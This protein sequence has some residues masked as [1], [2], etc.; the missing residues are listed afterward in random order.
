MFFR[1]PKFLRQLFFF[2][3]S[4]VVAAIIVDETRFKTKLSQTKI[5][6]KSRFDLWPFITVDA[7]YASR[8]QRLQSWR[9]QTK[10]LRQLPRSRILD[11]SSENLDLGPNSRSL[12]RGPNSRRV[13]EVGGRRVLTVWSR[14]HS[15]WGRSHCLPVL[16]RWRGRKKCKG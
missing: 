12:V 10:R 16:C 5:F 15:W 6:A 11:P 3:F 4:S 7:I 8:R 14:W 13:S 1:K 9:R 2:S